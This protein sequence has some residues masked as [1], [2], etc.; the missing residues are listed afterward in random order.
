M[1]KALLAASIVLVGLAAVCFADPVPDI[2]EG[3]WEI[4]T[5]VEIP[6]MPTNM[7]PMKTKQCLTDK[8]FV[9]ENSQPGQECSFPETKIT[10]NKVTYKR[11]CKGKQ[12]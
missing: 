3:Q 12:G 6:C 2:R 10:G 1:G 7:P 11:E 5:K 4:T 9:P 8:D